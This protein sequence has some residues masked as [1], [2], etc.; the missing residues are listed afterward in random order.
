MGSHKVKFRHIFARAGVCVGAMLVAALPIGVRAQPAYAAAFVA[1]TVP[2]FIAEGSNSNVVVTIRNTGTATW[3]QAQGDVFLATQRP[4]DNFYWCIQ[5]N[6]YGSQSGNRVLLP[7]DVAPNAEVTFNFVVKPLGC[8]FSAP[9]PLRFR[10]LSETHGTFGDETPDP[11]VAVSNAATFV[12]QQ[13][14]TV[15]PAGATIQ[16]T[17]TVKNTTNATWGA[18]DGYSLTSAV[19]A[20]NAIW[21]TSSVSLPGSVAAEDSVT[22]SY[23]VVAPATPGTYNFQWQMSSPLGTPF[24]DV[25]P[26]T[27]VQVVTPGPVNY[28]GLWWHSPAGSES[29]WGINFAHQA[30]T[31]FATWFTYDATGK[32]VWLSMTAV[33]TSTGVYTGTLQ[34]ATGPA[35]SAVP[36]NP[37][38]VRN[39]GVGTGTITFTDANNATFAYTVNSVNQT[40]TITRQVFG[41]LP[42]CTFNLVNDLSAAYNYQDL[43]WAAP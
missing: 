17:E 7:N 6:V 5:G 19:P 14:P 24:G 15:V 31:I 21:G 42:T 25:S 29:G 28:G 2:S 20:G 35:F 38:L 39:V 23:F 40:K 13:V 10:M 1:Q 33:S 37:R 41:Q 26:A 30:D 4:Q 8:R 27:A 43:W 32:G 18:T 12:S 9:A 16:V 36:F 22:F 11:K 3:L 34:Q